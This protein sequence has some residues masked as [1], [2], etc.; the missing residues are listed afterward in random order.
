MVAPARRTPPKRS[1]RAERSKAASGG[2]APQRASL[3]SHKYDEI[4]D[5][6]FFCADICGREGTGKSHFARTFPGDFIWVETPPEFGKASKL[7][8][9]FKYVYKDTSN[10]DLKQ[11][12]TFHD[13]R[14][15][16][17]D[18]LRRPEIQTIVIDSGSDLRMMA[19]KEWMM[20]ESK[21][22]NK[23]IRA[24]HPPTQWQY[25]NAK[26]DALIS[27]I[28]EAEKYLVVTN[29][30]KDEYIND[31]STGKKIRKGHDPLT[32]N[33]HFTLEIRNGVQDSSWKRHLDG[34]HFALVH[35]NF[36]WGVAKSMK[37]KCWFRSCP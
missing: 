31:N 15:C 16:V 29:R 37:A 8:R 30:M 33:L 24:V 26:I 9:K 4:S 32:Y 5:A 7:L 14:L 36:K 25:P 28:K 35:K 11:A 21:R 19:G 2:G 18:A 3:A 17:E 13:I 22:K 34:H 20:E 23:V 12:H 27:S 1:S 6:S 10:V